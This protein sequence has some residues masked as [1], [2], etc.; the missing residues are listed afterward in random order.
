MPPSWAPWLGIVLLA[1][2]LQ[3]ALPGLFGPAT[4]RLSIVAL[5]VFWFGFAGGPLRGAAFGA[6]AG[7]IEDALAG[8][9]LSW[10]VSSAMCG[11]LAGLLRR[12]IV[13]ESIVYMGVAA[14]ALTVLR[15]GLFGLI[16]RVENSPSSTAPIEVWPTVLQGAIAGLAAV[17]ALALADRIGERAGDA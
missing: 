7:L 8:S 14:G 10:S 6:L 1:A 4:L 15:I 16:V 5:C 17:A 13:G 9:A 12:T 2:L 3:S 11:A